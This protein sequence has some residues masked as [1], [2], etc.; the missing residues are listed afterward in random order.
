MP[1]N[2]SAVVRYR[3]INDC[4][5]SKRHPF[6]TLSYLAKKCSDLLNTDISTSTIE[7]DIAAMK[8][9]EPVGY[10]APIVYS[11]L[12]KGYV[13][14][15]KGFSIAELNLEDDE[16]EALNFAAQ[17]LYQY[18]EVP[19]FA[20]F[21]SAIERIN[22]RFSLGFTHNEL[23]VHQKV[24]FEKPVD[25]KG[26]EWINLIYDAIQHKFPIHFSYQNIYKKEIKQYQFIPYLLKEHRN[27]WYVIGWR[28]DQL[29][30]ATFGLDRI[31]NLTVI[32]ETQKLRSDFDPA[33][34]FQYAT[35]IME[36]N[37]EPELVE[38]TVFHPISELV[39]L[40]PLHDSQTITLKDDTRIQLNM[41]VLVNEEL[42]AK[43]LSMGTNC[44]VHQPASLRK[45][46]ADR[47]DIMQKNYLD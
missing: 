25:T 17:L 39:A 47:I 41:T 22:T 12:E 16:W 6:P 34:F 33:K 37:A 35:G 43:I 14:S 26:F 5:T 30:Y 32:E 24:Q 1:K 4:I 3:I 31:L 29:K 8:Q 40:E 44:L 7:K 10:N 45:T 46:I 27:R 38:L 13:Y 20:N 42:I 11:K 2:K 28:N 18:K 9:P 23:I 19:V 36:T 21:K 15:E